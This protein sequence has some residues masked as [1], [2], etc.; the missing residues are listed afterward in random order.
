[1]GKGTRGRALSSFDPLSASLYPAPFPVPAHAGAFGTPGQ[2]LSLLAVTSGTDVSLGRSPHV[3]LLLPCPSWR[4]SC[5][6]T[7]PLRQTRPRDGL[8]LD[9]RVEPGPPSLHASQDS[10]EDAGRPPP[11]APGLADSKREDTAGPHRGRFPEVAAESWS[12]GEIGGTAQGLRSPLTAV[13]AAT[14]CA[15]TG[16]W[17]HGGGGGGTSSD[18]PAAE[19]RPGLSPALWVQA[20]R[21]PAG[22]LFRGT[23]QR[24]CLPVGVC[25]LKPVSPTG[26]TTSSRE[27]N[28]TG[29]AAGGP[30]PA[31]SDG[32]WCPAAEGDPAAEGELLFVARGKTVSLEPPSDR[33]G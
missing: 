22:G 6:N 14:L 1:M 33:P 17:G 21:S 8:A 5:V 15:V 2:F 29:R 28:Q 20:P 3:C 9:A 31:P 18:R 10:V 27:E 13:R 19:V 32:G 24:V 12:A 26:R 16:G 11:C 23:P 30:A 25:V 4:V 7:Q